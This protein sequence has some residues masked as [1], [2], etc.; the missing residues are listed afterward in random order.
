MTAE[1]SRAKVSPDQQEALLILSQ[2]NQKRSVK[3]VQISTSAAQLLGYAHQELEGLP[4]QTILSDDTKEQLEELMEFEEHSAD[5]DEVVKR[6]SLF[7]LKHF[8]GEEVPVAVKII[9]DQARDQHQW[10]RLMVKDER[11][12]I[13]DKSLGT[14][15]RQN[16]AGVQALSPDTGLPDHYSC[17]RYLE[18]I[19]NY[20]KSQDIESCFAVLRID[21]H[22][23]N[24]SRYGKAGCMQLL[25]HVAACCRSSFRE[26][27]VVCHLTDSTI[28]LCLLNISIESARVVLN[29]LRWTIGSNH[30]NFGGKSEFSVTVSVVFAPVHLNADIDLL[31]GCEAAVTKLDPEGRNLLV[32]WKSE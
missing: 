9:R 2:N 13:A 16:F 17:G 23:K 29:R 3:I 21:R 22:E 19:Q 5:L 32:E 28:G 12:Q 1:A 4:L 30:I 24:M 11:R 26:E 31:A 27:D 25:Q 14:V 10:F 20:A 15:I 6:I 7:R 18:T 8:S